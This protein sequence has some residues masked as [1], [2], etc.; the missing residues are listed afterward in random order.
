MNDFEHSANPKI[1]K[2]IIFHHSGVTITSETVIE[3]GVHIYR[4]VTFGT[5][6]GKAPY[7]KKDAKIASHSIVLGPITV[8]EKAMVAP[9]AVVIKDVPDRKITAGVPAKIIGDVT[10]KNYSF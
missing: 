9:G 2:G 7:I 8:G 1:A 5:K 3:T 4:N 10:E 6:N